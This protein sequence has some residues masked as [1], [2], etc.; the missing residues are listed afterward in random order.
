M[1]E[2][3]VTCLHDNSGNK[4]GKSIKNYLDLFINTSLNHISIRFRLVGQPNNIFI[5]NSEKLFNATDLSPITFG[6]IFPPCPRGEISA[7]SQ[8]NLRTL[9]ENQISKVCSGASASIVRKDV[10]YGRHRNL[11]DKKNKWSTMAGTFN[12]IFVTKII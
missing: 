5:P 9:D 11:K 7:N 10:L 4:I 12:T 6:V 3:F 2:L 8:I 1:D